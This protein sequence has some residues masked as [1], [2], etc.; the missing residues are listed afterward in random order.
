MIGEI[1]GKVAPPRLV[2]KVDAVWPPE[3]RKAVLR[4]AIFLA[5]IVAGFLA[6]DDV[7]TRLRE[8]Q[9]RLIQSERRSARVQ[10]SSSRLD[11]VRLELINQPNGMT[12]VSVTVSNAGQIPMQLQDVVIFTKLVK[13]NEFADAPFAQRLAANVQNG[14]FNN[15]VRSELTPN[16]SVKLN[17]I[18][19][20]EGDF[21][22]ISQD[23]LQ[24]FMNGVLRISTYIAIT[25]IDDS[26]DD[27]ERK[28]YVFCG[29][30]VNNGNTYVACPGVNLTKV[31]KKP[32]K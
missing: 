26:L 11:I 28:I 31:I 4:I 14:A 13:S 25:Y 7:N 10:A 21:M 22:A 16:K 20:D 27:D 18:N 3:N 9:N 32:S 29:S 15:F 23:D 2:S 12:E 8:A 19:Q 17:A 1:F 5:I 24:K 30:F 6:Y